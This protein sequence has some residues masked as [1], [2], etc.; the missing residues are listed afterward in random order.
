MAD[1]RADI[2]WLRVLAVLLVFV[3]HA[4]QVFSPIDDWH[5]RN[6]E[7]SWL[8]GQFT[9]FLAP[10]LM[11]LFLLLAG[12]SAWF[13]L[14]KGDTGRFLRARV[15]RLFVPLV[16]GTLL[17]VPPQ[18]YLRR[19]S[20]GQFEG[21]YLEFYPR[22]FHGVFPEGN[23]SYGH[24][25]FLAYL[26]GYTLAALPLFHW[27]QGERG[28]RFLGRVAALCDL[29]GGVLLL[30][31]PL[32]LGQILL[33]PHFPQSTGA[34]VGDWS[35]HA[36]LLP[37][38][39]AGFAM[40]VEPRLELALARDWRTAFFP[41]VLASLALFWFAWPGD[42]WARIPTDPGAWQAAFWCGFMLASWSWL[43]FLAGA[44]R[45]WLTRS[46]AFLRYWGDRIYPLYVFH[47]T[48]IVIVAYHIV[49]WPLG[50][51][52]KF[53]LVLTLSFAATVLVLETASRVEPIRRVF[54]LSA[55]VARRGSGAQ[56]P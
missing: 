22:F 29:P 52:F 23:F 50:V 35:T 15:F 38:Y 11:P 26:F 40:M 37:V 44:A 53:A 2:D 54:G 7:T 8:L 24:L 41:A 31:V 49:A 27:L 1:R 9:V 19:L 12:Q 36:W 48:V 51:P 34:L 6:E 32:A 17:V 13:T 56:R 16:A 5:I 18:V 33:R 45:N 14:R 21:G 46:T 25:W 47:Q 28:R 43:V 10:W 4:A 20:R 55:P 39:I 30:F 42:V 3:V